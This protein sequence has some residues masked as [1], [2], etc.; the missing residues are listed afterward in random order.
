MP[1]RVAI[2]GRQ[3][4][5]KSTLINRL[6]GRRETIADEI[7]GVTRDRLELGTSWRGR[8]FTL[9]DTGGYVRDAAGIEALVSGQAARAATDADVVILVCD[10]TTGPQEEDV[11]LAK[12]LRRIE[13]PVL[14]VANK[15]D[16]DVD[17]ADAASLHALGLGDPVFISALHGRGTGDLLDQIVAILPDDDG[18]EPR[19][20][21]MRFALVGRPNVGKSSVFNRL[22]GDERAVVFEEAGT[23]R[24]AVDAVVE[25]EGTPVRFV[26]T[27]GLR[28]VVKTQGIEY[29]GLLRT[30]RAIERADVVLLVI[31]ASEGLTGDDKRI[32]ND[33]MEAGRGL[34]VAAN[35]WDLVEEKDKLFKDLTAGFAAYAQT[36]M[37][38]TS[39]LRGSGVARLPAALA[40]TRER[41][42]RRVPTAKVNDVLE[43]AQ[44]ERPTTRGVGR[45]RYGTQVT[46]GPPTFV[47]FGGK[48]PE[49]SYRRFLEH[50]LRDAFGFEGVPIRLRFRPKQARRRGRTERDG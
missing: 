18:S 40:A 13:V 28:S 46:A 27:A 5:G 11:D 36:Q 10:A 22:V 37:L 49:P 14:V 7:P 26:D 2:V 33:V 41:W 42:A 4:V 38:R 29:Y 24:D 34:V 39:A 31:D 23:T 19:V 25:W 32:A 21:E 35:K 48:L 44:A 47:L 16:S 50:R 12:R 1:P 3:N 45:F 6:H 43:R 17:E 15:V 20:Q 30:N 8:E 9:V